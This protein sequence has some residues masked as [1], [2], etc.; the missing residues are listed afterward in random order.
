MNNKLIFRLIKSSLEKNRQTRIPFFLV[1]VFT[2]MIFYMVASL[3]WSKYIVGENGE[4]FYGADNIA[5]IL[6]IGSAVIAI[7]AAIIILYANMFTMKDRRR[8][9]GLY[10]ILGLPKKSILTMLCYESLMTYGISVGGGLLIGTFLNKLML[11]TLYKLVGQAPVSGLMFTP[12]AFVF[13][14]ALFAGIYIICLIYNM[15]SIHLSK[16]VELLHSNQTGEKE[17][18]VKWVSLVIGVVALVAGYVVALKCKSSIEA[19]GDIFIAIVLVIVG[20]YGLFTAVSIAI[21]KWVKRNKNM[22]YKTNNFVGVANLMY[23][24]KHNAS[25]LASICVLSCAVI[26]LI[27]C[28]VSLVALGNQNIKMR[29]PSEV[30][31]RYTEEDDNT[32]QQFWDC[33]HGIEGL[34]TSDELQAEVWPTAMEAVEGQYGAFQYLDE[35]SRFDYTKWK[36]MYFLTQETYN[37]F[38]KEPISITAG[39]AYVVSS[40]NAHF[41]EIA[42]GDQIFHVAGEAELGAMNYVRDM[43]MVLFDNIFIVVADETIARDLMQGVITQEGVDATKPIC[44][45]GFEVE[46]E[47]TD[48]QM[49]QIR[50]AVAGLTDTWKVEFE[51]EERGYFISLYGGVLFVGVFLGVVFLVA[52]VLIIY[53]KQM[54]EG[55]E[56]H[57]RYQIMKKVGLTEKEVR[58]SINRQVM[59]L[60]FL[61]LVVAAVHIGVAS[62]IIRLFMTLIVYVEPVTFYL[63]IA[64]SIAVFALVYCFVYKLTSSQYFKIVDAAEHVA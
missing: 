52:T 48:G 64:G 34:E 42:I 37:R 5:L 54:S 11:L 59:I 19:L 9:I 8:E 21:L 58:G 29:C 17:P 40:T 25:G 45:S 18:K 35:E 22:Y 23:R 27:S 60:F 43:S 4:L 41:S 63:A 15:L 53:Y 50:D 30:V 10:G 2:S 26:L 6:T 49:Q 47:L 32:E 28:V 46:G 56:D 24:M 14:I 62:H 57:H 51:K 44:T 33:V 38:A 39:E 31:V 55:F 7:I 12:V 1:G 16:P 13:T 3:A 20:T 61:P 36:Q